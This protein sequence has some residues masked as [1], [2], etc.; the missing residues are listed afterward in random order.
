MGE[1]EREKREMMLTVA[2]VRADGVGERRREDVG[3]DSPA[4][5]C[6]IFINAEG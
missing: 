3:R 5:L 4:P 6:A 2:N 1:T